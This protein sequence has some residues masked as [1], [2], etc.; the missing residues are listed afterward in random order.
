MKDLLGKINND[1]LII[2]GMIVIAVVYAF[3]VPD[4][5]VVNTIVAGFVGYIGGQY[6]VS[7]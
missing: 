2:V 5:Q 3:R 7:E 4:S 6:S 1:T